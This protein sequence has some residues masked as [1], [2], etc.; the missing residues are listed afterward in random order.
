MLAIAGSLYLVSTFFFAALALVV[1]MRL[2]L[3]WRR[4]R[5]L[6]ELLLGAGVQLTASWGYGVMIFSMIARQ[7]LE[8]PAHPI[9]I[10]ATTF[11]WVAH[12][13]GVICMLAFILHVFRPGAAWARGLALALVALLL[14]GFVGNFVSGGMASGVPNRWY[15]IGFSAIGVYPIWMSIESTL[16]GRKMR[17]RLELGLADAMVVDRFRLW[18]I[19]SACAAGAIWTVNVPSW[20]GVQVGSDSAITSVAM[21]VTACFGISTVCLYWLTFFPPGWYRQR[22]EGRSASASGAA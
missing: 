1:G 7:A 17:R 8:A 3:L 9:G 15:W 14:V 13:L 10:A 5:N 2:L 6:P 12:D 18:A 4:T 16:Y 19:A 20:L 22:V 21:I 11:G